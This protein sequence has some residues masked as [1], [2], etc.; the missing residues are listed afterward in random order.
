VEAI[1]C[2]PDGRNIN[3][4]CGSL[5]LEALREKVLESGADAGVAFD[6]DADRALF[7]TGKGTVVDG[8]AV[9]WITGLH[10][11]GQGRLNEADGHAAIVATVMTNLGLEVALR[12]KGIELVRTPVGDK[13]VL[14]EM[15]R[16]GAMLGG[17]QSGHII[18]REFATTGDGMLTALRLLEAVHGAGGTLD[19]SA[20]QF[21]VFPQTL[22]NVRIRERKPLDQLPG[23][24]ARI[25]EAEQAFRSEGRVL[26]RFS[27]TEPLARV[28]VEGR[29]EKAVHHYAERIAEAIRASIGA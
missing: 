13:Y 19:D 16:R 27:G 12:E 11:H 5:H 15:V 17:E 14:E 20:G 4:G 29:E 23:V 25:R 21:P 8:D 10:L 22:V 9:M 1:G 26:V 2:A 28:M 7:V 3:L 24:E 6:G 18:F